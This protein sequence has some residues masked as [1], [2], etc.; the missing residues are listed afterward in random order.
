MT[1]NIH[2]RTS[3]FLIYTKYKQFDLPYAGA[4]LSSMFGTSKHMEGLS[5]LYLHLGKRF[6]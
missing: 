1:F 3:F 2:I 6:S 4:K 5:I